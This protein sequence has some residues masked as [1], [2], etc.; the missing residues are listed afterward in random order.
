MKLLDEVA[1]KVNRPFPVKLAETR[2]IIVDHFEEFGDKVGV[3]F[4]GGK[5]SQVVLYL[6]WQT[7]PE[8]PVVFNNTGVEYP[9]TVRFVQEISALWQLNITI[10]KPEKGFWQ[11]VEEYGFPQRS[12]RRH[13]NNGHR[14]DRS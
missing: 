2:E 8:V 4:S 7:K 10:T 3:A 12:K 14:G 13:N 1:E 11:C 9:E 6:A 5:D